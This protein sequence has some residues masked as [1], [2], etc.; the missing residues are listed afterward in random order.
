MNP[1]AFLGSSLDALRSFPDAVRRDAGFQIERLQRGLDPD[2]WKPMKTIGP[3]AREIR[4]RAASGAYRVIYVAMHEDAIYVLHAFAKKTQA[5]SKR[6]LE[7]AATRF[8]QL[9]RRG[10]R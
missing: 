7:L 2:D 6:D 1:V 8:R 9:M 3:G 5:T 4:L 10:E